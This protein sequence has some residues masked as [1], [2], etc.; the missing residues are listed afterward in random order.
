MTN[1]INRNPDTQPVIDIDYC[2]EQDFSVIIFRD[3][4]L[5]IPHEKKDK[6]F[7]MFRRMHDHV[8]GTGL[9][10]YIV[11]RIMDNEGGKLRL[12]PKLGRVVNSDCF[13]SKKQG[14]IKPLIFY[15]LSENGTM[16][17][18]FIKSSLI[19]DFTS[20]FG[21]PSLDS[22]LFKRIS[23]LVKL[24]LLL[25]GLIFFIDFLNFLLAKMNDAL[26]RFLLISFTI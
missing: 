23:S 5:G 9:G 26:A 4:G 19:M 6:I 18:R 11:K 2:S 15:L 8:E 20:S 10:L 21:L 12:T 17:R 7:D 25:T 14:L 1:F 16:V 3:N 22:N 24:T 13:F